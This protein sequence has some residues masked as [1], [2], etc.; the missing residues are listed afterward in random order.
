MIMKAEDL[1]TGEW[2]YFVDKGLPFGASISCALFQQFSD[3]LCHLI[4][5]K[6]EA[7]GDITNYLDDFLFLALTLSKCDGTIRK[8]LEL[9]ETLGIPVSADRRKSFFLVSY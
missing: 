2:K 4:E 1:T 7:K 9:C 3:T 8:F 5:C 6:A